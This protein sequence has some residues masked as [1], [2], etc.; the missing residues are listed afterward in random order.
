MKQ[1]KN[2]IESDYEYNLIIARNLYDLKNYEES[3]GVI[4]LMLDTMER[5]Q[6]VTKIEYLILACKIGLKVL[7]ING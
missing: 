2:Q 1:N 3:T 4:N 7:R 6:K 5:M